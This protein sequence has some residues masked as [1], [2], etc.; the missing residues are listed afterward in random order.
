MMIKSGY[1]SIM[2]NYEQ[3]IKPRETVEVSEPEELKEPSRSLSENPNLPPIR[4]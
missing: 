2:P 4:Y 3:L 1:K